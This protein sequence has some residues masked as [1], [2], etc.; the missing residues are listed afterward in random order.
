MIIFKMKPRH[1]VKHGAKKSY[2]CE[3]VN[4]AVPDGPALPFKLNEGPQCAFI[5]SFKYFL[6]NLNIY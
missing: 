6:I 2:F 3:L 5:Q 4:M 1:A